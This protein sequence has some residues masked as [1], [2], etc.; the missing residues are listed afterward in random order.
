MEAI[1]VSGQIY[2]RFLTVSSRNGP[3]ASRGDFL[4]FS[5][6]NQLS[7]FYIVCQRKFYFFREFFA[8]TWSRNLHF[9][10]HLVMKRAL[11]TKAPVW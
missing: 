3:R 8:E 9:C 4:P 1:S 11:L 10:K 2:Y 5:R 6:R 7:I